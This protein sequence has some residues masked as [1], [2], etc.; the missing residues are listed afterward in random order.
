MTL[1]SK[2]NFNEHIKI[3]VNEAKKILYVLCPLIKYSSCL[4]ADNIRNLYLTI[5]RSI[6]MKPNNKT[7]Y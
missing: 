1:D 5:I 6:W 2:F 4:N 7:L 3:K